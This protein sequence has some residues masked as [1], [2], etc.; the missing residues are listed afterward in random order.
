MTNREKLIMDLQSKTD[1]E[2]A[3]LVSKGLSCLICPASPSCMEYE[4]PH[5]KEF[6]QTWLKQ[7]ASR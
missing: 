1:E 3:K 7:E 2:L 6:F 5:C 4:T